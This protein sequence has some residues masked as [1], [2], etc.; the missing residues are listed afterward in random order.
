MGEQFATRPNALT[1]VRLCL[2]L[3]VLLWHA[4]SLPASSWLPDVAE[5]FLSTVAVDGFFAVSGFLVCRSWCR[6]PD[7]G[8]FL[9]AR[10]RRLLPG[11]WVCLLVTA[12]VVAPLAAWVSGTPRPGSAEQ[13]GYVLGNADTW[14]SSWGIG[15]G[16]TGVPRPGA[17]NGSLWSLG[18]EVLAYGVVLA[19]GVCGLLRREVVAGL[20]LSCWTLGAVL[21]VA[22]WNNPASAAWL[23]PHLGFVFTCGAL[24]WLYRDRVPVSGPLAAAAAGLVLVGALSPDPRLVAAPATAYLCVTA[25]LWLGRRPRL[26]L[27]H[28]LSYGCFLYGYPVQQALL[29]CGVS[30]GWAGFAGL[31]VAAVLPLAALSWWLVERPCLR[32][33]RP[34]DPLEVDRRHRGQR[35]EAEP[36]GV[37][38]LV[39][40]DVRLPADPPAAVGEVEVLRDVAVGVV[41]RVGDVDPHQRLDLADDAGLLERL[42]DDGDLRV[43]TGVD[44]PADRRPP[45]VV[46]ASH[47]DDLVVAEHDRGRPRQPQ[48]VVPHLLA[49]P[50]D[51]VG[52]GHRHTVRRRRPAQ[53]QDGAGQLTAGPSAPALVRRARARRPRPSPRAR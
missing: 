24:L 11:L 39:V 22:G 18:Y 27:R 2:T 3:E 9:L 32:R 31:S 46:G 23:A 36:P 17:W 14:V 41:H 53:R 43:L 1:F 30:L 6:R 35:V 44:D 51:E 10:A 25:G 19:L 42:P 12:F 21:A 34:P 38:R 29:L 5:R 49:E 47:E 4:Y 28:D 13:W 45:A 50:E 48:R 40:G 16:P 7:V 33:R 20:A 52:H 37:Q 8:Q 26:V 15:S